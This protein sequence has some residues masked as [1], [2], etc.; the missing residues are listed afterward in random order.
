MASFSNTEVMEALKHPKFT[1][2]VIKCGDEASFDVHKFLICPKSKFLAACVEGPFREGYTNE[3]VVQE[4]TPMAVAAVVYYIYSG[5]YAIPNILDIWP[6][7][8]PFSDTEPSGHSAFEDTAGS[9]IDEDESQTIQFPSGGWFNALSPIRQRQLERLACHFRTYELADRFMM[10][11]LKDLALQ[12]RMNV[13][14]EKL[15]LNLDGSWRKKALEP[16]GHNVKIMRQILREVYSRF[17]KDDS[18]RLELISYVQS[19]AGA[20][21]ADVKPEGHLSLVVDN[22]PPLWEYGSRLAARLK[23][24]H[25]E[26]LHCIKEEV[27]MRLGESDTNDCFD[28]YEHVEKWD[29]W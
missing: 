24:L 3:L 22:D 17:T 8:D 6:H 21:A 5:N 12:E 18:L 4:T 13:I 9:N 10:S 15:Y 16:L 28:L 26:S 27:L 2:F 7:L 20:V 11:S 29:F 23:Q 25:T 19:K 1:D 14:E